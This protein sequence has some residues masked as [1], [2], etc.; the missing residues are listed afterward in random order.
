MSSA[1][2]FEDLRVWREARILSNVVYDMTEP[3]RDFEFRSQM[4]GAA[5]SSMNNI[6][7]GFERRTDADFAHFLDMAKGSSGE[8]RSMAYLAEDR[9]FLTQEM[10]NQ[11]REKAEALSRGIAELAKYLRRPS[12]RLTAP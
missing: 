3:L 6:A 1:E 4:R 9:N 7:E 8:V 10:S 2:R 5:L 11:L 12:S